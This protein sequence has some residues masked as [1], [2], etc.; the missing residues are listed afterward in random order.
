MGVPVRRTSLPNREPG[1]GSA[2]AFQ[3]EDPRKVVRNV[4]HVYSDSRHAL[5]RRQGLLTQAQEVR[6]AR[7][8]RAVRR[9][10]RR[11]E[12]AREQLSQAQAQ[13][14]QAARALDSSTG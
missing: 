13:A 4:Y 7:Q 8:L 6:R 14:R 11:V 5:D 10:S 12:R 2:S 3:I 1:A 9:S